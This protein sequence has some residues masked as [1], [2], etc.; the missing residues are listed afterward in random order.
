[1]SLSGDM[2]E[3]GGYTAGIQRAIEVIRESDN[4]E[5]AIARLEAEAKIG[6]DDYAHPEMDDD[7]FDDDTEQSEE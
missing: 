2:A 3:W 4:S 1:M 7:F 5:Q 6:F